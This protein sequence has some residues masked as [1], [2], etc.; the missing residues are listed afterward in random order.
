MYTGK[1]E[2][3]CNM[4]AIASDCGLDDFPPLFML[5]NRANMRYFRKAEYLK[6]VTRH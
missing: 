1:H 5:L 6:Q 4:V 2:M 3:L